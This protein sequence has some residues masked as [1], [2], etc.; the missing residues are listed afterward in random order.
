MSNHGGSS[1]P[2]IWWRFVLQA[3]TSSL[4]SG[5]PRFQFSF[6]GNDRKYPFLFGRTSVDFLSSRGHLLMFSGLV[7]S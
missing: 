2:G 3:N 7:F 6:H 1:S 5:D 4:F